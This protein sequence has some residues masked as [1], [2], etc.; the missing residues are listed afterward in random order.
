MM[1]GYLTHAHEYKGKA[2]SDSQPPIK[3]KKR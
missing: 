2:V 3:K 1:N